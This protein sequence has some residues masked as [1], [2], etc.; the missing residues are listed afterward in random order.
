[1]P[2]ILEHIFLLTT[3]EMD[4]IIPHSEHTVVYINW[5]PRK[6]RVTGGSNLSNTVSKLQSVCYQCQKTMLAIIYR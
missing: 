4:K 3:L 5:I 2:L 1:M 6:K